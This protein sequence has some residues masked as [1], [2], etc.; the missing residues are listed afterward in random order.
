MHLTLDSY[1]TKVPGPLTSEMESKQ[2]EKKRAQK[3][4]RKQRDREQKE[5]KKKQELEEDEKR[6]FASLTDRE[7]VS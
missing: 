1:L 3:V 2:L 4:L 7:K 6:R 5:E